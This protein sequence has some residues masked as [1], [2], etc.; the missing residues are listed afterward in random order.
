VWSKNS[1]AG[2]IYTS[3]NNS[4]FAAQDDLAAADGLSSSL[5]TAGTSSDPYFDPAM[6]MGLTDM[7]LGTLSP[8]NPTGQ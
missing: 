7:G 8:T 1:T 2:Q 3:L 6:N 5:L 4:E